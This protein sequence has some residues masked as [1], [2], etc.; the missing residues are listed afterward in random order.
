MKK[1]GQKAFV[2]AARIMVPTE[3]TLL[4]DASLSSLARDQMRIHFQQ[5]VF[6]YDLL[7]AA[8]LHNLVNDA[9]SLTLAY[10]LVETH[11]CAAADS[12]VGNML[13]PYS[14]AVCYERDGVLSSP[15]DVAALVG[16]K[17]CTDLYGRDEATIKASKTGRG[18]F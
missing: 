9:Q 13:T 15:N 2:L 1:N 4:V 17:R 10:E 11:I 18:W 16:R 14:H 12:F 8:H 7:S 5:P 6:L 3:P